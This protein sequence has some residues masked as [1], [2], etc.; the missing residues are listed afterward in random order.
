M[1][2]TTVYRP[3]DLYM[4]HAG[5][6]IYHVY[7]DNDIDQGA[8]TY[9]FAIHEDGDD[10]AGHEAGVFDV[11][12][13]PA[14]PSSPRLDECPPFMGADHGRE[15]GFATFADWKNS[16]EFARRR[17]LWDHW[18]KSGEAEAIRNTIRNAI[19]IGL[20]TATRVAEPTEACDVQS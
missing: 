14:P 5:V 9:L 4:E 8:R 7:T 19:D 12:C 3:A 1:P 20:I 11:R 6:K 15:A 16:A 2:Y 17:S 10:E 18:H 13:L